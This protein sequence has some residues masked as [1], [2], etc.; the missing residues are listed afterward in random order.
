MI[1]VLVSDNPDEKTMCE[2]NITMYISIN[3]LQEDNLM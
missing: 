2:V 3:N 1:L